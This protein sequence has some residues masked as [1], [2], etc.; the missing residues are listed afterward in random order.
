MTS[1]NRVLTLLDLQKRSEY[2]SFTTTRGEC[3]N[4]QGTPAISTSLADADDRLSDI[5]SAIPPVDP[6][7][8]TLKHSAFLAQLLMDELDLGESPHG[9]SHDH[10]VFSVQATDGL[11][12]QVPDAKPPPTN[13]PV[14]WYNVQDLRQVLWAEAEGIE[15]RSCLDPFKRT[16]KTSIWSEEDD[17]EMTLPDPEVRLVYCFHYA[18]QHRQ[19]L[20]DELP[21]ERIQRMWKQEKEKSN[22][23]AGED[24]AEKPGRF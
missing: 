14:S 24:F 16:C 11:T 3:S 9:G 19:D 23:H 10:D 12:G 18:Q 4:E 20:E 17:E 8:L 22:L 21:P 6:E 13:M 1:Q 2:S 7:V 15:R 5:G